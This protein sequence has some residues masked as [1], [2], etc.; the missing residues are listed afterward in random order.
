MFSGCAI[1]G[2]TLQL[3][4]AP[5]MIRQPR[6]YG[7][8]RLERHMVPAKVVIREEQPQHRV[9]VLPFLLWAFVN[10]VSLRTVMRIVRLCLSTCDVQILSVSG[11]PERMRDRD[12]DYVPWSITATAFVGCLV[13]LDESGEIYS[14]SERE[15]DGSLVG[16]EAV[17]GQLKA[18][19]GRPA[20]VVREV[21]SIAGGPL[22]KVP[23]N[24]QLRRP[25][26]SR[27][28]VGVAH[29]L[30]VPLG[31]S[32]LFLAPDEPPNLVGLNVGNRD[33]VNGRFQE[34]LAVLP[35]RYHR[36]NNRVPVHTVSRSTE[37]I[38]IAF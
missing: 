28:A 13:I 1:G 25:F 12:A 15:R 38:G 23:S 7:R 11:L 4:H 27:E 29:A 9:V 20:Q 36:L 2:E 17:R 19:D 31:L 21:L 32:H 26:D 10:R 33:M 37:R 30:V 16:R 18:P 35:G 22:A 6:R 3:R 24:D 34:P 8:R 14:W 5:S